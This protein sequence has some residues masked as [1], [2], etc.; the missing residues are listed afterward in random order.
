MSREVPEGPHERT[1]G[2]LLAHLRGWEPG[3]CVMG[4]LRAGEIAE[5]V[6][7]VCAQRD[8]LRTRAAYLDEQRTR[9]AIAIDDRDVLIDRLRADNE[10]LRADAQRWRTLEP[11]FYGVNW[12]MNGT[13]HFS[14][15]S[16]AIKPRARTAAEAIDAMAPNAGDNRREASGPDKHV[17]RN[18]IGSVDAGVFPDTWGGSDNVAIALATYFDGH[19]LK[20]DDGEQDDTGWHPWVIQQ[21]DA[22]L[23]AIA[24]A[25]GPNAELSGAGAER[26]VVRPEPRESA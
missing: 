14:L 12:H 1:V 8:R 23:D 3:A 19:P 20:P 6:E 22:T 11:L 4:N 18:T 5:A 15:P 17:L 13:A 9:L 16:G 24:A 21:V 10:A 26:R 7:A 2:L 25:L